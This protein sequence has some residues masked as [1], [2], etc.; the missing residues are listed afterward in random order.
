MLSPLLA[1]IIQPMIGERC[2]SS[3][4]QMSPIR[5][6]H[7]DTRHGMDTRKTENAALTGSPL[8]GTPYLLMLQIS[9]KQHPAPVYADHPEGQDPA[10]GRK[11]VLVEDAGE[12]A[13]AAG[14]LGHL[15]ALPI[16]HPSMLLLRSLSRRRICFLSGGR[17]WR[18]VVWR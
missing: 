15:V 5:S 11:V 1:A 14:K 9:E 18:V 8:L 2:L 16:Q 4:S 10:E 13:N 12:P 17:C 3:F 7:T 6:R